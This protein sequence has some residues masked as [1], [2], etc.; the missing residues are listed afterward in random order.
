MKRIRILAVALV[1]VFVA[2]VAVVATASAVEFL[3]ALW[4]DGGS[5]VAA[6]LNVENEG[7]LEL[8]S[9]NGGKLGVK[10][11]ILCSGILDGWVAPESLDFLSE[12]LT[13]TGTVVPL[14]ELTGVPLTCTNE[15][16]CTTPEVWAAKMGWETEAELMVDGTETFF[17]DLILNGGWYVQCLVLGVTISETCTSPETAV[18]LTNEANGTIDAEFSDAFQVLAGLTLG[19]CTL[20]GAESA[21][22][23]GLAFILESG[24]TLAVSSE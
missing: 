11:K 1:A 13:L 5:P 12:L 3:L 17:T 16:N 9:L 19:N 20:G 6:Q 23:N 10:A 21:E 7:E 4:L 18:K 15:E 8:V 22:V 24:V 2:S 14:A